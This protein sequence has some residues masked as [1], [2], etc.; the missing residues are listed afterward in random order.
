MHHNQQIEEYGACHC[1]CHRGGPC[2]CLLTPKWRQLLS[3]PRK[4]VKLRGSNKG[5]RVKPWQKT[6]Y[7]V[8]AIVK[9]HGFHALRSD[10]R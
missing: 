8:M 4:Q 3:R 7:N 5:S 2:T 6:R 9:V 10:Y 1:A